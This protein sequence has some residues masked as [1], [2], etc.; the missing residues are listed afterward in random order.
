M[1][2][3]A[4]LH[5]GQQ[6]LT[7]T[8]LTVEAEFA[9]NAARQLAAQVDATSRVLPGRLEQPTAEGKTWSFGVTGFGQRIWVY[10]IR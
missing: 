10:E 1:K 5:H 4:V 9:A 2:L 7:K 6:N 8:E 3:R